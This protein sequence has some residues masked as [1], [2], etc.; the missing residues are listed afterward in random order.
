M[1]KRL[2]LASL[3]VSLSVV[4]G[5]A[6][7]ALATEGLQLVTAPLSQAFQDYQQQRTAATSDQEKDTAP[8]KLGYRPS[9]LDRSHLTKSISAS[10]LAKGARGALPA[11]YDL[12]DKGF[13]TPVRNQPYNNCWAYSAIGSLESTYLKRTGLALDLSETHLTWYAYKSSPGFTYDAYDGPMEQGGFD[14]T[15]VTTLA[16]WIG[17]VTESALPEKTTPTGSYS[18]YANRL[19]LEDAFFL[20][21]QFSELNPVHAAAKQLVYE[22]GAISVGMHVDDSL[23]SGGT[24][25]NANNAAYYYNGDR[26]PNHAVLLVGWDD[27]YSRDRFAAGMQPSSDGAWLIRNSWGTDWGQSGYFWVSYE[28]TRLQDGTVYLAGETNNYETLYEHDELGWCNS[29]GNGTDDT[30]WFANVFTSGNQ[31]QLIEAVSLYTTANNATF[32]VH[33]YTG[34]GGN[35]PVSGT[36]KASFSGSEELAGY[37]TV[38]LPSSVKLPANTKFS[39]VV[40]MT[41]PNYDYPIPIEIPLEGYSDN[42]TAQIGESYLSLNGSNWDNAVIS[43]G[44]K[45]FVLNVCVKAFAS[46]DND[47]GEETPPS[48]DTPISSAASA[49]TM[50]L[51]THA[52]GSLTVTLKTAWYGSRD[53]ADLDVLTNGLTDT[54]AQILANSSMSARGA[55]YGMVLTAKAASRDDALSAQIRG[56]TFRNASGG[57][58]DYIFDQPI[59]LSQIQIASNVTEEDSGSGGGGGGCGTGVGVMVLA[60]AGCAFLGRRRQG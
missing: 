41:T 30:I 10:V 5:A 34:L 19:H 43:V 25:Y 8:Y 7:V 32:D 14:N 58:E 47:P 36:L 33:I 45:Q 6:H 23:Y 40:K 31:A 44:G 37:H 9:P 51:L 59:R 3:L 18:N 46:K 42:A 35:S 16:R 12:R 15:S 4:A 26:N 13:L 17:A 1:W 22:H 56:V 52:N 50:D 48:G 11:A 57:L 55:S 53:I 54:R 27:N 39:V 29:V 21:L 20:S 2:F 49:W 24:Y 38:K 60:L 28:D